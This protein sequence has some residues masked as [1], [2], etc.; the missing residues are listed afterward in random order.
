MFYWVS[1]L[2]ALLWLLLLTG[3]IGYGQAVTGTIV[4]TVTD[5]NNAV[6]PGANVTMTNM[7]TN[8]V[9]NVVTDGSGNYIVLNLPIGRYQVSVELSGFKREV[10]K[11]VK[12]DADQKLRIDFALTAGVIT[13]VVEVQSE[14]LVRSETSEL[15]EVI[16][17][18]QVEQLPINGR[19]FVQLVTLTTGSGTGIPGQSLHGNSPTAFRS[20]TA[21][22]VNSGR[23][24]QN[25]F[26]LDGVDNNE[27]DVN[28]IVVIPIIDGIQEFKVLTN[29]FS[30]E[31]G[32][33]NSAIISVQT[34][35]GTNQLHGTLYEFHRNSAL[36]AKNFFDLPNK[37]IPLFIQNQFGGSAGGPIIKD[38][39]FI[40]G[41]YQGTRIRQAQTFVTTVPTLAM[42]NGDFRGLGVTIRDPLTNLPFPNNIVPPG[43]MDPAAAALIKTYPLPNVG[44]TFNNFI[45]NPILKRRDDQFDIRVDHSLS[46]KSSFFVRY[47]F[48]ETTRFQPSLLSDTTA[49]AGGEEFTGILGRLSGAGNASLRAQGVSINHTYTVS[50]TLLNETRFGFT[51][52]ALENLPEGFGQNLAE[53]FGIPGINISPLTS[54]L[55]RIQ[56]AGF[57]GQGPAAFL[58]DFTA[59]NMFQVLDNVTWIKGRHTFKTGMDFRRRQR[60]NYEA[61]N[62]QGVFLFTGALT[63]FPLSDFLTGFP[64]TTLRTLVQAFGKRSW[65]MA[66]YVQDDINAT[67]RLKLNLGVRY[68]IWSPIKEVHNRQ[69]NFDLQTAKMI[70]ASEDGP[71]GEGL[72][73]FD[74]NNFAPR[75]GFAYDVFGNTRTILRGGFGIS[76]LEDGG[77]VV[78]LNLAPNYPFGITQFIGAFGRP[79]NRLSQGLS[80]PVIPAPD[81]LNPVGNVTFVDPNYK[82]S[83]TQMWTLNIQHQLPSNMLVDIAYAGSQSVKQRAQR[84]LNQP[85]PGPGPAQLRRPYFRLQPGLGDVTGTFSDGQANYHSLQVKLNRRLSGGLTFLTSYTWSK[86]ISN[87]EGA[88][89]VCSGGPGN[90]NDRRGDRSLSCQDMPHRF[91]FSYNYELPFGKNLRGLPRLLAYGWQINGIT[92]LRSGTPFG[93][94]TSIQNPLIGV[95]PRPDRICD[96]SLPRDR[97][98]LQRFFDTSCFRAPDPIRI[99]GTSPR[100][101]LRGPGQV[102]FDFSVL[103]SFELREQVRL[104]FRT[105]IFNLF[106]TPQF[107]LPVRTIDQPDAGTIKETINTSRQ[108]Q[109]ALKLYF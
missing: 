97:R 27:A 4:G 22:H 2:S 92:L 95:A 52:F 44:G 104:Q 13:E 28:T 53:Q 34:K 41:D 21:V 80:V 86:T 69:A 6:L 68:E 75:V 62:Q 106:N 37:K 78:P 83:Y 40:F 60:N 82:A 26:L 76:F 64:T 17:E 43:A 105:E 45:N 55:P 35:S 90:I 99:Y 9:R 38:R 84:P 108:I 74:K 101:V 15:G 23:A 102:N 14:S 88:L 18:K 57:A 12:L 65:E 5:Q 7:Q 50:Q 107:A 19:N 63:G 73:H 24:D 8:Q 16:G 66:A 56:I 31:Y 3:F 25:N 48:N 79:A 71:L 51:R 33:S 59:Q 39:T 46:S 109:F 81:P 61:F 70:L 98:T 32:R 47:S 42:R 67:R 54:G 94:L 30:A 72:R 100:T 89:N 11:D 91:V 77:Q 1:R 103:K 93:L 96:G 58:P 10:H 85:I 87:V 49:P 29:N 20:D 36:D